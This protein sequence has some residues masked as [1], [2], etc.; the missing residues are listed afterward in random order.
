MHCGRIR[1]IHAEIWRL[2]NH[3]KIITVV[4]NDIITTSTDGRKFS[5]GYHVEEGREVVLVF[6]RTSPAWIVD[7]LF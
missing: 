5:R 4:Y 6:L 7:H 2:I 1:P 3:H